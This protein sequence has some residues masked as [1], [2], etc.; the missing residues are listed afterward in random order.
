[1]REQSCSIPRGLKVNKNS[2]EGEVFFVDFPSYSAEHR[3]SDLIR[4][5]VSDEA[6]NAYLTT[7]KARVRKS[8]GT[9]QIVKVEGGTPAA[10]DAARRDLAPL[11][12]KP[13]DAKAVSESLW[14]VEGN[15]GYTASFETLSALAPQAPD[16]TAGQSPDDGVVVHLRQADGGRAILMAGADIPGATSNVTR[17]FPDF[18]IINPAFSGFWSRR[19]TDIRVRFL[20]PFATQN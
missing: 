1:M 9:L 20:T 14:R 10:D 11:Q 8:P 17:K 4:Y 5:R 12:G 13:I 16:A 18:P 15:G 2:A 3:R 6:W 7:R 19:R